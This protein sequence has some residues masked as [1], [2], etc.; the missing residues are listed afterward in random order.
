MLMLTKSKRLL[1]DFPNITQLISIM[2][3]ASKSN[4]KTAEASL[5]SMGTNKT[6]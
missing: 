2:V 1:S 6:L 5:V 4:P 3:F